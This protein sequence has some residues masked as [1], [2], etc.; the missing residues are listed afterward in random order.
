MAKSI[1]KNR[2]KFFTGFLLVVVAVMGIYFFLP[3]ET[4]E[5]V[6]N[7]FTLPEVSTS[8]F[9]QVTPNAQVVGNSGVVTLTA[10]CYQVTANTEVSQAISVVNGLDRKSTRLNSSH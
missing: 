8:G 1:S 9:I 4:G 2:Y 5:A 6:A 10:S 3:K 7:V